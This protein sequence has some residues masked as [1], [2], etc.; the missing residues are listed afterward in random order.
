MNE[1]RNPA[2][3]SFG[4]VVGSLAGDVQDLV[5]GEISLARAEL[6]QKAQRVLLAAIWLMGGALFAAAGLVVLLQGAA[7]VFAFMLPVWAALLI[8]G[9]V[10]IIVGAIFARLG[11]AMLSLKRLSPERTTSNL[12]ED[13]RLLRERA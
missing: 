1:N 13:V 11:L 12:E 10:I 5:R 7:L 8:V 4:E 3:H 9:A 6:G 2:T